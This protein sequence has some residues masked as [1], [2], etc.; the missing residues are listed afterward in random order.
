MLTLRTQSFCRYR[1]HGD[2]PSPYGERFHKRL[3]ERRF[4]PLQGEEERTYGWVTADNLLVT[5]FHLGTVM[6][7]EYAAF[8]LRVDK[9]RVNARLL[10]ARLDLE[11]QARLKAAQDGGGRA[12]LGREERRELREGLRSEMLKS[13]SPSVDAYTV[14]LQPKKKL[15]HV[16][17]LGR[18]ANELVRLHF[19]D[20]FEADILPLTPWHR[21][22]ELLEADARDGEDLR[23]ALQDLRRTD[24]GRVTV[25]SAT[26]GARPTPPTTPQTTLET[27]G[28]EGGT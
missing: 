17:S 11:V 21:S 24:F 8:A 3:E 20:T 5:D 10:R 28:D 12:R 6:R 19:C 7:G 22:Q 1:I 27:R 14:L 2:V 16:L 26:P 25:A 18:A 4:L 13:T 15:L 23:P 9:R